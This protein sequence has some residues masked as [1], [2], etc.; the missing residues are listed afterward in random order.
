[1]C[2]FS[3]VM[4]ALAE[5]AIR[6]IAQN[7]TPDGQYPQN[8]KIAKKEVQ[9]ADGKTILVKHRE[10]DAT[11]SERILAVA[12]LFDEALMIHRMNAMFRG[13]GPQYTA[14]PYTLSAEHVAALKSRL[15]PEELEVLKIPEG[16]IKVVALKIFNPDQ[17]A[18][19][20]YAEL[21]YNKE[22]AD[23]HILRVKSF[24]KEYTFTERDKEK[25]VIDIKELNNEEK[26]I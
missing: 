23:T 1:M 21:T 6:P 10:E 2:M 22:E 12:A 4:D 16:P 24:K 14:V 13:E 3:R 26:N 20:T 17:V 8:V 11:L 15:T 7:F 25:C 9:T 5:Q 19:A 18:I